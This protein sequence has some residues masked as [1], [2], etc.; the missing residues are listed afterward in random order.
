MPPSHQG[1]HIE[2]TPYAL[3]DEGLWMG[4]TVRPSS[5]MKA[6]KVRASHDE[7]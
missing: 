5:D 4:A 6:H 3:D 2:W 7:L 1:D